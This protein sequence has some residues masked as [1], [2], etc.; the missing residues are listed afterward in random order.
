MI[1]VLDYADLLSFARR[2]DNVHDLDTRWD[3][4]LS[5]VFW[6]VSVQIEES[7]INSKPY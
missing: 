7:L 6:K 4:V 1:T 2:N 5:S 3:E